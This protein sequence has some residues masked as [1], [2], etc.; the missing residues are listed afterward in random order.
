MS[1]SAVVKGT[2]TTKLTSSDRKL[3]I[4]YR[5]IATLQP[6]VNNARTHSRSQL[7]KLKAS[8]E[9][10]GFANP[11]LIQS[12]GMI[13]AGH[14]RVEAAKLLGMDEVP[15]ICLENLNQDQIRAYVIADNRLAELAGWDKGLLQI[16]LQHLLTLDL[17]FDVTITD[18]EVAEIDLIVNE[19]LSEVDEDDVLASCDEAVPVTQP[20]DLWQL[21]PH[22][23]LCSSALAPSSFV[24]LMQGNRAGLA[25]VDPPYNVPIDGHA[26]GN[27]AISHREFAMASGEM[28]RAQFTN[29]LSSSFKLLAEHSEAGSVHFLC[30]DWRHMGELLNSAEPVYGPQLGLC[31]W[32]K[33]NAGMGSLYRSQHELVFV[34]KKPGAAHRNN[35]VLGKYGR[36]RTNVWR[37]PCANTLSRQG[38]EGNL[39]NL[40]PT[41]KPVAMVADA[42]LDCSSR[43]D[44][45][46][47]S[48]LGSGSTLIAA[49]RVGRAC[50][51]IEIDPLYVDVAIRR[52]HAITGDVAIHTESGRSFD[53]IESE[54]T[55]V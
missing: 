13:I 30:M 35:I 27:G 34:Y 17:S 49:E 37:Y 50:Y 52:W 20:G 8:I 48:F 7:R 32:A 28:D 39:L 26:S 31:V 53:Q 54:V 3:A 14:G 24:R 44:I 36:N 6:H 1:Q 9:E 19:A 15:T 12:N 5:S 40:H 29:F 2:S 4:V 38:E 45:V 23:V 21:G 47:D 11:I 33:D 46:L 41:V 43:A 10:F 22:R 18:F 25:F 55:H 16:E 51:G 42:I